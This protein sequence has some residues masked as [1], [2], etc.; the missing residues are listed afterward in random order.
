MNLGELTSKTLAPLMTELQ[1]RLQRINTVWGKEHQADGAHI[2]PKYIDAVFGTDVGASNFRGSGSMTWAV[3]AAGIT[4]LQYWKHGDCYHIDFSITGTVGGAASTTLLFDVPGRFT[5]L[6]TVV[7][8]LVD[9]TDGGATTTGVV[10]TSA[11]TSVI[12]IVR[13]NRANFTAGSVTAQGQ[14]TFRTTN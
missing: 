3:T 11:N 6:R 7:G 10:F 2:L 14:I 12:S 5:A 1:Q 4:V 9:I 13:T 8:G